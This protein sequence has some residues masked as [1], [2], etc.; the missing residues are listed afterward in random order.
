MSDPEE[1]EGIT[2]ETE[3][4][5]S[6]S[7]LIDDL[8]EADAGIREAQSHISA[9][10]TTLGAEENFV[11]SFFGSKYSS[12]VEDDSWARIEDTNFDRE[13]EGGTVTFRSS[14]QLLDEREEAMKDAVED[15][16][17]QAELMAPG[18]N[19]VREMRGYEEYDRSVDLIDYEWDGLSLTITSGQEY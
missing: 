3:I 6:Y 19:K 13:A 17:Y 14:H 5:Y 18:F 4:N 11:E 7:P 1:K 8:E 12:H 16:L 10:K 9:I 15:L 2:I